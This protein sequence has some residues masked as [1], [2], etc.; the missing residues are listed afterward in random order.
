M[1]AVASHCF[2]G[3]V[4]RVV[5]DETPTEH[6]A[7]MIIVETRNKATKSVRWTAIDGVSGA[8]VWQRQAADWW[9]SLANCQRGLVVIKQFSDATQPAPRGTFMLSAADGT[10]SEAAQIPIAT[11]AAQHFFKFPAAYTAES[12]HFEE[13]ARF[14]CDQ[15]KN[16]PVETIEY[17]ELNGHVV[18][19]FYYRTDNELNQAILVVDKNGKTVLS[20]PLANNLVGL[21]PVSFLISDKNLYFVK[22]KSEFVVLGFN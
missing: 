15:T 9:E 14:V 21:T 17:A 5:F 8:V 11:T 1:E 6:A 4:W 3:Q 12:T 2:E 22:N 20:E 18:L 19:T 13:M 7:Q 10:T 16:K